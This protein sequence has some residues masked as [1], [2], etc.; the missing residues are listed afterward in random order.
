MAKR[1]FTD[2]EPLMF[3]YGV[4][5]LFAGHEHNY[6]SQWPTKN[7]TVIAKSYDN[8]KGPIHIVAGAGGAPALDTFG[9]VND[10]TRTRLSDWGYGQVSV[11]DSKTFNF[12]YI[13]NN[14]GSVFD[15]WTV[16]QDNHGPFPTE[17]D[18]IQ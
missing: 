16:T 4:D 7:G 14:N 5:F 9:P 8:P 6:E 3:K 17:S 13:Y 15:E 18:L 2:I 1:V 12:K 10:F 11:P